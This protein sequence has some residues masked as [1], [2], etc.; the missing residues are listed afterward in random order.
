MDSLA[1]VISV[2]HPFYFLSC[3]PSFRSSW[4][5]TQGC[6]FHITEGQ[7]LRFFFFFFF[8]RSQAETRREAGKLERGQAADGGDWELVSSASGGAGRVSTR[9]CRD[10]F[11]END[12]NHSV[13]K[14]WWNTSL[15]NW[16]GTVNCATCEMRIKTT[17]SFIL[18][19]F[20]YLNW[21]KKITF[22]VASQWQ[23]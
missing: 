15:V 8:T 22:R 5:E 21:Q 20:L 3:S 16:Y 9:C 13:E 10:I 14:Y 11:T 12:R 17:F 19:T 6:F 4:C 23:K 2:N 7:L 18:D 1:V